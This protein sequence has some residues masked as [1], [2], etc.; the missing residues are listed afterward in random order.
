MS[1]RRRKTRFAN[2]KPICAKNSTPKAPLKTRHSSNSATPPG[3]L[4]KSTPFSM[5]STSTMSTPSST[6]KSPRNSRSS[7]ATAPPPKC[8]STVQSSSCANCTTTGF[9]AKCTCAKAK[10]RIFPLSSPPGPFS[11][12]LSSSPFSRIRSQSTPLAWPTRL[13]YASKANSGLRAALR[14][15]SMKAFSLALCLTAAMFAQEFRATISGRVLDSSGAA[16]VGAKV[17]A[18]NTNTGEVSNATTETSGAYTVPF[19]RPGGYTVR[20]SAS[21]FKTFVRENITLQV[22]QIAGI[23]VTLEVGALTENITVTAESALLETQT[24]SRGGVV[25]TK[26]VADLPL[27]ARNPFMLGTMMSGVTFRGAAIWQRPF[28]NGAIA[29]WSVNGS[30]QSQNEFLLDGAP[31]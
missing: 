24:A 29:Q 15:G 17:S 20:V 26:Q 7:T 11:P 25:D 14:K 18:T 9:S 27:N 30:Q 4:K 6:P 31:N 21:G 3:A 1:S 28:D 22:G 23:E 8:S 19:L 5:K 13:Q 2:S 12:G 16:V 10:P